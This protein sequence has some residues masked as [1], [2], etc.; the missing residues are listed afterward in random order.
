MK[1]YALLDNDHI[2]AVV[3]G[4]EESSLPEHIEVDF[5]DDIIND[6]NNDIDYS[7]HLKDGSRD[8]ERFKLYEELKAIELKPITNIELL[9]MFSSKEKSNKLLQNIE[10]EKR[11]FEINDL[12]RKSDDNG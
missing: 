1:R 8:E 6:I 5:N 11:L 3:W 4:V 10:K 2:Y 12:I 7:L 9:E